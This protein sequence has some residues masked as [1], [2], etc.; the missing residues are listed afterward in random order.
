[1]HPRIR[2]YHYFATVIFLSILGGCSSPGVA[3]EQAL[4]TPRANPFPPEFAGVP[5]PKSQDIGAIEALFL[6]KKAPA[7][8]LLKNCDADFKKLV[9]LTT[10]KEEQ[11]K[12][13]RELVAQDPAAYHWC[14]YS[15]FIDLEGQLKSNENYLEE[16]QK[17]VLDTYA[18]LVP[19]AKAFMT[20][21]SD[22]RYMRLAIKR[23]RTTSEWVFFRKVELSPEMTSQLVDVEDP[24]LTKPEMGDALVLDKYGIGKNSTK[25]VIPKATPTVMILGTEGS[26]AST[27]IVPYDTPESKRVPAS[28]V[29]NTPPPSDV[30]PPTADAS[31]PALTLEP[32]P[33]PVE[34]PT[35]VKP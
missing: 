7:R 15:K 27:A 1:M 18:F 26:A 12:G 5:H 21:F 29:T 31:P 17:A 35:P 9:T 20:E 22:S 30:P 13:A 33:G 24:F 25:S 11:S 19:V 28:A 16:R 14:F 6:E 8:D 32:T 3:P 4:P 2:Q 23:Y 34:A 10:S